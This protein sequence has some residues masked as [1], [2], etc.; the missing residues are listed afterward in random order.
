M[1]QLFHIH[2]ENPQLR[3]ID[4]AAD[5]LLRDGV[6]VYPTDSAYAL[7]CLITNKTGVEKISQI[8]KIDKQHNFT[9]IVRDLSEAANYAKLSNTAYRLIKRL[10]PGPYTF[11]LPATR[12]V[13]RKLHNPKR[14]TIGLRIPGHPIVLALLERL[15]APL[16]SSTLILPGADLPLN[17]VSEIEAKL[18]KQVELIIDGGGCGLKPTTVIGFVDD[19]PEI[20][21]EGAG[22][23]TSLM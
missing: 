16:M 1:S 9:L 12:E 6:M 2:P 20:V 11:I 22:D 13:P 17:D 15:N 21:R 14:K 19:L 23:C 4:R 8:R 5:I 10:T 7:G 18:G 3:L